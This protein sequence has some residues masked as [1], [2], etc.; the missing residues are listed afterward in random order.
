MF[1]RWGVV[2][3]SVLLAGLAAATWAAAPA[4][5][6]AP[7]V[8]AKVPA[9][10]AT[11]ADMEPPD[12]LRIL[13]L[14]DPQRRIL[15]QAFHRHAF[16]S[17]PAPAPDAD[18]GVKVEPTVPGGLYCL[19]DGGDLPVRLQ[20]TVRSVGSP[21]AVQL[22]Y[23]VED[24]Y[25]RKVA[26]G[27][28]S[29][30]FT[31]AAGLATA[32]LVLKELAA[33]GYYHVIVTATS[34]DHMATGACGVAVVHPGPEEA[35]LQ[36]PFG[37]SMPSSVF[38]P[39]AQTRRAAEVR[40]KAGV[41]WRLGANYAFVCPPPDSLPQDPRQRAVALATRGGGVDPETLVDVLTEGPALVGADGIRLSLD[42]CASAPSLRS[43]AYRR[44][45]DYAI[46]T[47]RR[48]GVKRTIVGETGE[49]PAAASPQQQA[50]KLVTRSVLS[51]AAGAEQVFIAEGRGIPKPLPA[52]TA[53][54][55]MTHLLR[56]A[57]YQEDIWPDVPL[58]EAHLF[59]GPERR[60]AVVWSWAGDDLASPRPGR[61]T[62]GQSPD[63]PDRGALVLEDGSRLEA[64]DVMGH[65]VGIWKG[66]RL[67]VPLGEA[68]IWLVSTDLAANQV[69]DRVRGARILGI[70]PAT[71]W[72]RSLVRGER[73]DRMTATLWVQSHRPYRLDAVAGLMP[74]PGWRA[75]QTKEQ[76][77]LDAGQARE[78]TFDL[79]RVPQ[80]K[81][82]ADAP[83]AADQPPY[84]I[85]AAVTLGEE[86]ARRTQVV[87]PTQ[88]HEQTVEVGYG[89]AAWE[90]IEPVVLESDLT[91]VR[92][93]VRT[94][95]DAKF[96]YFSAA[97][98]R[99][100]DGFKA[101]RFA[102]DGDA[103]QLA[104]GLD[105]RADDDFG[106]RGRDKGLPAGAFRDTDYLVAITFGKAGAQVIRLRGPHV[107]LR[108]HVPGNMDSWY[109]PVEGAQAAIARDA[110][111]KVTIFE[112]AIPLAALAPL[113]AERGRTFR[114]GFRIGDGANLPLEWSR[115]AGV[116]DYLA[117]PGSFLPISSAE[118]LPCQTLWT[119]VGPVATDKK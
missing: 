20:V 107:M 86:W 116:P 55:W 33:F 113:K 100:R 79:E 10:G 117:G 93:E 72:V 51:L 89:L 85:H 58:I 67:I 13:R 111:K 75:R 22:R 45:L 47:A 82:G 103:I 11:A 87:W 41:L 71:V 77:G 5:S 16:E 32:D 109:G 30:A 36:G 35:D 29:P 8:A 115:V 15:E 102:S 95:W 76:F 54:A 40:N 21:A 118:D 39:E 68:P 108:D 90:G 17:P 80:A 88:V 26:D 12:D 62:P 66:S 94:A 69:R 34:Q 44:S 23:Y 73:P 56:G 50:W 78:L 91:G 49:D 119:L 53:Y 112:A 14:T 48:M 63:N 18:F 101:G 4:E 64:F 99:D 84:E 9:E 19:G 31:D 83:P 65:A 105:G 96:F 81:E 46:Q 106:G 42:A 114:F 6:P 97:V 3:L 59:A 37:L 25:G 2:G 24:F 1:N 110:E 57:K 92:A 74:P 52:A 38:D 27:K 60:V 43:G 28:L 7:A 70:A 98:H 61:A 104:W